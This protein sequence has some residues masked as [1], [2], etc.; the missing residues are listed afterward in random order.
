MEKKY[1]ITVVLCVFNEGILIIKALKSLRNNQLFKQTEIILVD[2]CSTDLTTIK[3][4]NKLSRFTSIKIIRSKANAGLSHSRNLGFLNASSAY[5]V[6]LDADDELPNNTLDVVYKTF[7]EN[8]DADF[9]F[10]NY[11]LNDLETKESVL[12]DCSNIATNGYLDPYKLC[13]DWKLL[14]TSPCKKAVWDKVR[15]Y[16][17]AYSYSIQDVEFWIRVVLNG[18]KGKYLNLPLYNWHKSAGG[19]NAKFDRFDMIKILELHEKFYLLSWTKKQLYNKIFE[20][21][22]PYKN[23]KKII[24][25]GKKYFFYLSTLNKIRVLYAY[26]IGQLKNA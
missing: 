6:P 20:G 2:D 19:M 24:S 8:E 21:Y 11:N 25:L 14:G 22:Y 16:N 17:L 13:M 5:I 1:K 18:F 3:L 26:T 7:I 12:V 10:G 9:I 23:I 15:G 4:I